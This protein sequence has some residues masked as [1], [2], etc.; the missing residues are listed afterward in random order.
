MG[1][2]RNSKDIYVEYKKPLTI[3]KT[4][5]LCWGFITVV[6]PFLIRELSDGV[7]FTD[8]QNNLLAYVFYATYFFFGI[9]GAIL[10]N[11]FGFKKAL[12]YGLGVAAS[13]VFLMVTGARSAD[14]NLIFI[15]VVIQGAGF[16]ILQVAANP[17]VILIGSP[18]QGSSRLSGA[19]AY[20]SFGTWLAPLMGSLIAAAGVPQDLIDGQNILAIQS[21]KTELVVLPY[22]LITVVFVGMIVLVNFSDIPA[23]DAIKDI[24]TNIK[25][26]NRKYVLQ[27]KHVILGFF[28][29]FFYVGAEVSIASKL[30]DFLK[31]HIEDGD[32]ENSISY[33]IPYYWGGAMVG[34][35]VGAEI[36]K[37]TK[38]SKALFGASVLAIVFLSM[39]LATPTQGA[40]FMILG[41]GLFNSIMWPTIFELGVHGLGKFTAYA[42]SVLIM[43]IVGGAA[44]PLVVNTMIEDY[45]YS[46]NVA[47]CVP[48]V[49]YMYIA[50]FALKGHKYDAIEE[51]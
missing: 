45:G 9:S 4:I 32:L 19:G 22:V 10:I 37:E 27:Y 25:N 35:F 41:V 33:I 21:F 13:S 12:M 29:V 5:F 18:E 15:A 48:I 2:L 6:N 51:Y 38:T 42:S 24:N 7:G 11:K 3:V 43:G 28:A 14:F 8:D 30:F 20:N 46:L 23:I 40:M 36:L 31:S 34:R 1:K 50:Y 49:C 44:V 47:L 17:Y 16:S 26:D 39:A